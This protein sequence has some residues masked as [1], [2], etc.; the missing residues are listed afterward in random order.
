MP[1][2]GGSSNTC[3][4]NRQQRTTARSRHRRLPSVRGPYYLVFLRVPAFFFGAVQTSHIF[5][6]MLSRGLRSCNKTFSV[7]R[8]VAAYNRYSNTRTNFSQ[9]RHPNPQSSARSAKSLSGAGLGDDGTSG[10]TTPRTATGQSQLSGTFG[11]KQ[12][13]FVK[14]HSL[15]WEL[16]SLSPHKKARFAPNSLPTPSLRMGF[17][18]AANRAF[19]RGR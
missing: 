2:S 12:I 17:V 11:K 16:L 9:R 15:G 4:R 19:G 10:R 8:C 6:T 7:A 1:H 18:T 14:D 5:Y 13:A 3:Q